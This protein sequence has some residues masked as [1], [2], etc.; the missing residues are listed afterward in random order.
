MLTL[1]FC[2]INV[3]LA[4]EPVPITKYGTHIVGTQ[5]LTIV[6]NSL[7]CTSHGNIYF[8]N[9]SNFYNNFPT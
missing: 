1:V 3:S 9:T 7:L 4:K 6:I 2:N 8:K 5:N